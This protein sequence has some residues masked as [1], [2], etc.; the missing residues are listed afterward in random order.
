MTDSDP[1]TVIRRVLVIDDEDSVRTALQ[2]SIETFDGFEVDTAPDGEV[3]LEMIARERY[4]A[5]LVDLVMPVIDGFEVLRQLRELGAS[6]RPVRV[7]LV[8]GMS[9]PA[10]Q[11]NVRELGGDAI[12]GKPFRLDDLRRLLVDDLEPI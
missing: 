11:G 9:D 4:D 7:I 6:A 2:A 1:Q 3:G 12:L 10:L 8:S 5:V